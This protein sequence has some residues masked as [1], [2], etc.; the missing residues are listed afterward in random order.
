MIFGKINGLVMVVYTD[1]VGF[2]LKCNQM[3]SGLNPMYKLSKRGTLLER[4]E[5]HICGTKTRTFRYAEFWSKLGEIRSTRQV[6]Y[7]WGKK[8]KHLKEFTFLNQ[9]SYEEARD[10]TDSTIFAGVLHFNKFQYLE[11]AKVL[12]RMVTK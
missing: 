11:T 12:T 10:S 7:T 2:C 5:C 6:R 1:L 9:K 4:C 8:Y 3:T